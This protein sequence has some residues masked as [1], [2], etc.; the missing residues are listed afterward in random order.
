M[1]LVPRVMRLVC[2][3]EKREHREGLPVAF[4]PVRWVHP[5]GNEDVA[6]LHL[7]REHHVRAEPQR[8][9][10]ERL[11]ALRHLEKGVRGGVLA[12]HDQG[13]A[14]FHRGSLQGGGEFESRSVGTIA[15]NAESLSFAKS[16]RMS[17]AT[18]STSRGT[19]GS[20]PISHANAVVSGNKRLA[21]GEDRMSS[22]IRAGPRSTL[23]ITKPSRTV[24]G[25][26]PSSGR[27][28]R[29]AS[30]SCLQADRFVDCETRHGTDQVT[31]GIGSPAIAI[32]HRLTKCPVRSFR[33]LLPV[34]SKCKFEKRFFQERLIDQH[35]ASTRGLAGSTLPE[36]L[37]T[38]SS[39]ASSASRASGSSFGA[40]VLYPT[41]AVA[42]CS[43]RTGRITSPESISTT[44]S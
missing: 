30:R 14:V 26:E 10:F 1:T 17:R 33:M 13:A 19:R 9:Q 11:G 32:P 38:A 5:P 24:R 29:S 16:R 31:L 42:T 18:S 12:T 22:C 2:A 6:R 4:A 39:H 7:R 3:G 27:I 35:S 40:Q 8:V 28:A 21:A 41:R 15:R 36:S 23:S 37:H 25:R 43:R 20:S 44:S 34:L